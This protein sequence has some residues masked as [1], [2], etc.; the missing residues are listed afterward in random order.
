MKM[1]R[2]I[3]WLVLVG[4]SIGIIDGFYYSLFFVPYHYGTN[5]VIDLLA[6][7]AAA[8]YFQSMIGALL[9]TL[10]ILPWCIVLVWALTTRER[11]KGSS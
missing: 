3:P 1:S 8:E 6:W 11:S 5:A 4:T 2:W 7:E 10:A 9:T